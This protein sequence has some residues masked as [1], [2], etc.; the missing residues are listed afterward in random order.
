[1]MKYTAEKA[2][3]VITAIAGISLLALSLIS[4]YNDFSSSKGLPYLMV[5]FAFFAFGVTLTGGSLKLYKRLVILSVVTESAFED[6]IY[7][8]LRP[9][10][11]EI[12]YGTADINEVKSRI[13]NLEKKLDKIEGEL[14]RPPE[15]AVSP[16]DSLVL[17]KTA[18]YMRTV[19]TS[20]FFFGAYLFILNYSLP[21]EPYLYTFLY[22]LWWAFITREFNLFHRVEAWVVLGI[23]VLL[24]PAGSIILSATIGIVPLMG[25][26]FISVIAYAYLY[27]LYARTLTIEESEK[28][29]TNGYRRE[30]F[31]YAK[32]KNS[33]RKITEWVKS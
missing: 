13:F 17:R 21:F 26:I 23:P 3:I 10:L 30:N 7:T 1:M 27:Y 2:A 9:V 29:V 20:M 28:T 8:R 11:E 15:V 6:I 31:L 12:A 16:P 14:T 4:I 5:D 24:V 18:F 33:I 22:V 19:I 32:V 25:L